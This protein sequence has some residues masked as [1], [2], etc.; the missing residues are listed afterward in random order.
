MKARGN[1]AS[2]S[3]F[4]TT[5]ASEAALWR[6][7]EWGEMRVGYETYLADFDDRELLKGLPDGLCPGPNW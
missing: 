3:E 4:A 6:E 7:A 1:H 2:L 5:F